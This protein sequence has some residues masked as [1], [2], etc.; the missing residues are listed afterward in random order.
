MLLTLVGAIVFGI[1]VAGTLLLAINVLRVPIP[2][3]SIPAAAGLSVL[4]FSIYL[5]YTWFGRL[6]AAL[7]P[8]SVIAETYGDASPF[9]PWTFLARPTTRFVAVDAESLKRVRGAPN[10]VQAIVVGVARWQPTWTRPMLFDC[11]R[12]R[13]ADL[14]AAP[15]VGAD[16]ELVGVDWV[17][18]DPEDGLRLA[19]RDRAPSPIGQD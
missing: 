12:P 15:V 3:W 4:G 18:V 14:A 10:V 19:V 1:A 17:V 8:R 7:S 16:G 2:R 9:K 6:E 5:D 13:R 11:A